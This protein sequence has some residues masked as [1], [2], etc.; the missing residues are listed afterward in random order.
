MGQRNV[1]PKQRK[2]ENK[3][4]PKR[5]TLQHGA[6]YYY[7][8]PGAD[9]LWDG[10][11]KMFRLGKTLP[12]AYKTWSDRIQ[13]AKE[14]TRFVRQVLDRYLLEVVPV[15]APTTQANNQKE[16]AR[17]RDAFGDLPLTDIAPQQI[18]KYYDKRTRKVAARRELAL[19]SHVMTKAVQWGYIAAH[20]F[21]GEVRLE[22]EKPRTR[23]ITDEEIVLC[24]ALRS[25][26]KRGSV[27]A[28]QAYIKL[29]LLTGMRRGDL[30]RL[31][32]ADLGDDGITVKTNKTGKPVLYEWS[33]ELRAAVEEAKAARP[34]DISPWLFCT[35]QGQCY[36]NEGTGRADGWNS[37]WQRFM[38][39]VMEEK[40]L[41]EKFTE[42]DLRAKCASD[43]ST[44]E[45]ARQLLAHADSK[46]TQRVY[47][48]KPERV[49]PL[50]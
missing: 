42:H 29:K 24:L 22:T 15:K 18:Y 2:K 11:K 39:R 16:A 5:W 48:R 20:P 41:T 8:P 3:G 9:H 21:K 28:I 32:I 25:V 13:P 6:Y 49:R 44:L 37:M 47:R 34:V 7:I 4:L 14:E 50:R 10:R 31:R 19:L 43:A 45:H 30:L 33:D 12:E 27:R 17:I 1:V 26:R 40:G 35:K 23:Y 46:I 38:E 36:M